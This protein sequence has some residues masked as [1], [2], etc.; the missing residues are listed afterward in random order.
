MRTRKARKECEGVGG[1]N[2]TVIGIFQFTTNA[3]CKKCAIE[4]MATSIYKWRKKSSV[5]DLQVKI[6]H[7]ELCD[8]PFEKDVRVGELDLL[9]NETNIDSI[10]ET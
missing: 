8:V 6:E 9:H 10:K 5:F 2:F 4:N 7:L 3:H 1:G